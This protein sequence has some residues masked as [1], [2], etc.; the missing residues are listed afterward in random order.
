MAVP[1]NR[2]GHN[3]LHTNEITRKLGTRGIFLLKLPD[4][5]VFHS[6]NATVCYRKSSKTSSH[7]T[8]AL[9]KPYRHYS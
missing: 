9:L 7:H 3:I 8:L 2:T 6:S 4:K 1:V 5:Y